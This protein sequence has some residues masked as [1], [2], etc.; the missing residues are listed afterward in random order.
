M[1][2]CRALHD[3]LI[4]VGTRLVG[5]AFLDEGRGRN[6]LVESIVAVAR[7]HLR[8]QLDE[9]TDPCLDILEAVL[10]Q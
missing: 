10:L 6:L 1:L 2:N 7:M 8:Q 3:V 4:Q 5:Q 9:A